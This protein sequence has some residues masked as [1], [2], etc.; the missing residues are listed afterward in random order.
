MPRPTN[1]V[2]VIHEVVRE[3][4]GAFSLVG[5]VL[6]GLA[7]HG[8]VG[9]Q[10]VQDAQS[11]GSHTAPPRVAP[12][13]RGPSGYRLLKTI[14]LGGEGRWD[15]LT[16]DPAMRRLFISRETH[17]VVLDV[18]HE[19]VIG[20]IP[21]T[22]G[23]HAIALAPDLNRGFTSNGRA[24]TVTI[25]DLT[26]LTA[27][28]RVTAGQN[29][30]AI[31][32]EPVSRDVFAMNGHSNDAT[33]I[34]A[35]TG[36]VVATISLG[37]KPEFAVADG[38]GR[39]YVNLEDKS[40]ALQIDA[41]TLK[42]TAR[43][44][45]AP[46]EGPSGLA[47]DTRQRRLFA[48]CANKVLVAVNADTGRVVATLPIGA[49]VDGTGFDPGAGLVF[50]SNGE[51]TLTVVRQDSPDAYSVL[52]NVPTQRGAR[53]M[54]LDP[55]THRVFLV[56]ADFGPAPAPTEENPRTRPP[57]LPDSFVVLVVGR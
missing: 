38:A 30:D 24:G 8:C 29:P 54:T 44:P 25:F 32:Y 11:A 49:G 28:D 40:E 45:L 36:A 15:A 19:K 17:V 7:V 27:I 56:T 33:V 50:S 39:V 26:T 12:T 52:E 3:Q 47:M 5:L 6:L 22:Q 42:V 13:S 1:F 51:G 4:R 10:A 37:G 57:I 34:R 14:H 48:G 35:G 23:V 16:F 53:T 55:T 2:A 41:R 9:R 21:D 46:C 20:D 31:V 43:W 18:D